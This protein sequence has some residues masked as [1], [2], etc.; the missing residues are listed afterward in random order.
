MSTTK[1]EIKFSH[2]HDGH[3]VGD[4][5][6]VEALEAKHLVR[7]GVAQRVDA[8]DEPDKTSSKKTTTSS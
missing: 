6:K 2:P 3:K 8:P 4:T 1:V 7:A 5:A